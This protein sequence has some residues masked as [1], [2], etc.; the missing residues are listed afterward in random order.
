M[1]NIELV[2][3]E[4]QDVITASVMRP[5]KPHHKPEQKP[6]VEEPVGPACVCNGACDMHYPDGTHGIWNA[7]T[8]SETICNA[9][10]NHTCG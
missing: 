4:A 5:H 7:A 8:N 6:P 9:V 10:G 2:R 3:F 1:L